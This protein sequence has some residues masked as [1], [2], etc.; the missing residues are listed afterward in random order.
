MIGCRLLG[1]AV[2]IN[3]RT[4]AVVVAMALVATITA[5]SELAVM[6]SF[7]H[8]PLTTTFTPPS[9]CTG[10]YRSGYLSIVGGSSS[11]QPSGFDSNPSSYFSPGLICPSGYASACHD[12]TGVASITTVTCC[13]TLS[14]LD[15]ALSC[16]DT[17]SLAGTWAT[18]FCTWIAPSGGTS[19]PITVSEAGPT[20]TPK[21]GFT[22]PGGLNAY[23]IRMVYQTGDLS[24]TA[25]T[26]SDKSKTSTS[27]PTNTANPGPANTSGSPPP[28]SNKQAGL[29]TGVKAAIGVVTAVVVLGILAGVFFLWKRRQRQRDNHALA[30][31]PDG[32]L[33]YSGVHEVSATETRQRYELNGGSLPVEI[34]G[35]KPPVELPATTYI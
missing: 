28:S 19:L 14:E 18:E 5:R 6:S 4:Q 8:N 9:D 21:L 2:H 12:N 25:T 16:V 10:I 33:K 34:G 23:G 22:S 20:S 24:K 27:D 1:C 30:L 35:P 3:P 17:T 32:A 7:R 13:P 29:S 26:T 15:I 11:C 31:H